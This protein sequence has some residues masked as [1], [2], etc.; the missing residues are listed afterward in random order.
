MRHTAPAVAAPKSNI[1]TTAP[2]ATL[3]FVDCDANAAAI[4]TRLRHNRTTET[5]PITTPRIAPPICNHGGT[6]WR[7]NRATVAAPPGRGDWTTTESCNTSGKWFK[8]VAGLAELCMGY[9][10]TTLP[11]QFGVPVGR[12]INVST[13][14]SINSKEPLNS[15]S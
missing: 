4:R 3:N 12:R 9:S 8:T 5:I 15:P 7:K 10:T 6:V 13:C 14:I 2:M 1:A 11:R